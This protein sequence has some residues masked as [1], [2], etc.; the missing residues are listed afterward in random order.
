MQAIAIE[1]PVDKRANEIHS[2]HV[3][4]RAARLIAIRL[5]ISLTLASVIVSLAG[6]G[7]AR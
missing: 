3:A 5:H 7:G 2:T 6:I 4:D 1:T